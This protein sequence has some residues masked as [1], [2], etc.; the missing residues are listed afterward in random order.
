MHFVPHGVDVN[1]FVPER[2]EQ[3]AARARGLC[4]FVGI[5][6]RDFTTLRRVIEIINTRDRNIRFV[7]VTSKSNQEFL[8]GLENTDLMS[9]LPEPELIKLYQDADLLLQPM[10][11]STANNA[12]LEGMSCGLPTIAADIGAVRDYVD[13]SS[14]IMVAP[15]NAEEMADAVLCLLKND[16]LR[17]QMARRARERALKFDWSIIVEKTKQVYDQVMSHG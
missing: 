4:L 15:H 14:G 3:P 5:H 16:S 1:T 7:V 13:D 11:D 6:R 2:A 12:I 17:I 10:E 9:D 8:G